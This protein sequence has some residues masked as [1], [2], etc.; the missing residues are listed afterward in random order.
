MSGFYF[1]KPLLP[2]GSTSLCVSSS[3]PFGVKVAG[4]FSTVAE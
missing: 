3:A 4:T 2:I 1:P